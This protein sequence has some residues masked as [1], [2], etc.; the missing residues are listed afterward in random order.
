LRATATPAVVVPK[1][2]GVTYVNA[3][4]IA[5][6]VQADNVFGPDTNPWCSALNAPAGRCPLFWSPVIGVGQQT[7]VLG[8][9]SLGSGSY[10]FYCSIHPG[11]KGTLVVP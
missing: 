7:P 2:S 3:D 1:G 6:D 11:M 10:P 8:V 9:S 5:H 4:P